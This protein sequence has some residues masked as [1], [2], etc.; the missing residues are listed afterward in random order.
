MKQARQYSV[1]AAAIFAAAW[2]SLWAPV[3]AQDEAQADSEEEEVIEEIIVTVNKDGDPVDVDALYLEQLRDQIIRD[4]EFAQAEQAEE[5]WRQ[6]LPT[7]VQAPGSRISWGYDPRTEAAM[8]RQSN[9][10]DL[11]F[12]R[13]RPATIISL[14][15]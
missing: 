4:Y 1:L 7:S 11:P 6:S 2:L 5:E 10:N 15:F 12:D 3:Q 14:G 8:R 9:I 13:N